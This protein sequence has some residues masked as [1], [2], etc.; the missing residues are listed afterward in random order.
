MSQDWCTFRQRHHMNARRSTIKAT[1]L[2][3]SLVI[4]TLFVGCASIEDRS[5]KYRDLIGK[6]FATRYDLK[7]CKMK[8]HNYDVVPYKLTNISGDPAATIVA[9]IPAGTVITVKDA[10]VSYVGGDWDFIIAEIV[11][12]DTR[13]KILYEDMLGFSS[14]D[15]SE[16]FKRYQTIQETPNQSGQPTPSKAPRG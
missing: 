10:K 6:Q 7:L 16:F 3:F 5:H 12:P 4:G 14:V 2:L 9:S 13:E 11:N 8:R 15:P 1:A